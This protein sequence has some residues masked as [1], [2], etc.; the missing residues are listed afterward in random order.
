[1]AGT[2]YPALQLLQIFTLVL[3][4][5]LGN[6]YFMKKIVCCLAFASL[7]GC[8]ATSRTIETDIKVAELNNG[9]EL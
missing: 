7:V 8:A 1:V 9:I 5:Y 4:E 2:T 6:Y 3:N